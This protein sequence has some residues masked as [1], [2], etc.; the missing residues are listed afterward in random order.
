MSYVGDRGEI[1]AVHVP[2]GHAPMVVMR[3]GATAWFVAP[4]SLTAGR[5]GL[6]RWDMGGHLGTFGVRVAHITHSGGPRKQH[7]AEIVPVRRGT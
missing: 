5:Y 3:S 1:S 6:F 2:G 4:G 7:H